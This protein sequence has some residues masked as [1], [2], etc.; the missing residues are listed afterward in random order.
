MLP[1][2]RKVFEAWRRTYLERQRAT[3]DLIAEQLLRSYQQ[4]DKSRALLS[5]KTPKHLA[6]RA[7]RHHNVS[8]TRLIAGCVLFF[9]LSGRDRKEDDRPNANHALGPQHARALS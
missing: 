7:A 8:I 4:L 5:I 2:D 9:T 3:R 1:S 6:S